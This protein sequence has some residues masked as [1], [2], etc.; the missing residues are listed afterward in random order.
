MNVQEA[1]RLINFKIG[2]MDDISSRNI[3]A[4]FSNQQIIDELNTQLKDYA[5]ITKGIQDVYS[6]SLSTNTPF[7]QAPSL[8]LRSESYNYLAVIVNGTIFSVDMRG[9]SEVYNTFRYSPIQGITNWI[10]PWSAG[11][12]Q[13][14]SYFPMNSTANKSTTLSSTVT[15]TATT[16]PVVSTTGFLNNHGRLTIGL[17]KIYYTYKD[18][19][20]FYGCVRGMEMTTAA[21][22]LSTTAVSENNVFI[23]YNRLPVSVTVES[24]DTIS[25]ATLAQVL[26]PCDEHMNGIIK[27]VA[28]NLILKIDTDRAT[29]YKIDSDKLYEEYKLEILR[30]YYAGR[31]GT[32]VRE[33]FPTNESG[34]PFGTNLIY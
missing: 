15:D 1:Y 25:S 11:H 10:M 22:H 5:R 19:T 18:S 23:H 20:N 31:Q 8:A 29:A 6:V 34:V 17:E 4:L 12:T 21:S 24:D 13:Y 33:P 26:E 32:G 27:S 30:G 9:Q 16:I 3:N 7:I 14:L 28:Y 2:T